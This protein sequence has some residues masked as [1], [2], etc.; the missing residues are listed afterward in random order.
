MMMMKL[1]WALLLF[2]FSLCVPFANG[3]E[4]KRIENEALETFAKR[5]GPPQSELAHAVIET[6]AWDNQKTVIAFY[7][8]EVKDKY[9][10]HGQV[11]GYLFRALS[12]NTYQKI[13]I[14]KFEPEGGDPKIE[15][16]FFANADKDAAKELIVICSWPQQ[17][18]DV[19]GT[20]YGTFIFDDLRSGATPTKLNFLEGV[21]NKVSG[22]CDCTYRN[23]NRKTSKYKTA[24]SVKLA[25]KRLGF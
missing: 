16:A 15:A 3:Q 5:N 20:L 14:E 8:I 13:L 12:P 24:A 1:R 19:S 21:S 22:G 6:E 11:D 23:G 25:L 4:V 9:G 18:Y 7:V 17:H 2:T 10:T